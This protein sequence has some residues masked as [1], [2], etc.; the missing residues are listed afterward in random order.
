MR[1]AKTKIAKLGA[2]AVASVMTVGIAVPTLGAVAESMKGSDG[3]YSTSFTSHNA[4]LKSE[5]KL[6]LELAADGFALMK[7]NGALPLKSN[8]LKVTLL[9]AYSYSIQ[10]GGGGSGSASRPGNNDPV[11]SWIPQDNSKLHVALAG[12]GFKI[13]PTV[14]AKYSAGTAANNENHTYMELLDSGNGVVEFGGKNYNTTESNHLAGTEDSYANYGDAAIIN[15]MRTG[16]EFSDNSSH[17]VAQHADT[18]EHYQTLNDNERQLLAYAKYLKAQGKVKKLIIIINSPSNMEIADIEDDDAFDSILWIGTTGWDGSEVVGD[19]LKGDVNPSGHVVDFWEKDLYTNPTIYNWG[20]YGPAA[21]IKSGGETWDHTKIGASQVATYGWGGGASAPDMKYAADSSISPSAKVLHYAE[22]IFMGYRYYETVWAELEAANKG[23]GDT[24][25]D[26]NVIYPF[27]HGLSYT[28]FE[29]KITKVDGDLSKADGTITVTVEVKNTGDVA[30]KDVVQL[31]STPPYTAGGIDKAAVNLINFEKTGLIKAGGS[32][33]VKLEIAVKDLANFDWNDKNHN[34]YAGYELE[35]GKYTLSVRANSHDVLDS[36]DLTRSGGSLKWDED[37]DESTPN[38]I[39][40]QTS[41]PWEMYN[42]DVSHWLTSGT[43]YELHRDGILNSAKTG[44]SDLSKLI[45]LIGADNDNEFTEAAAAVVRYRGT[46]TA[47]DD[48]D[49]IV[50]AAKETDYD[51]NVW[52]KTAA[53]VEGWTQGTGV[54]DEDGL[55]DITAADMIGVDYDDAK[56]DTFLNQLTWAELKTVVGNTN[57]G[58]SYN[59]TAL[60]SVGK[61]QVTDQDGPGQLKANGKNGWFWVGETVIAS[62]WNKELAYAQGYHVGSES[63]W[64]EGG[65]WYGPAMNTHR[66]CLS[67]RN[68]EY[69]SQDGVQAGLIAGNVVGG[70]VD[71]GGRVYAKHIFLNDQ[72]ASRMNG[73]ATFCNEQAIREIYAKPFELC[74]R[75]GNCN[76]FMSAFP[77]V[78]LNSSGSYAMNI[79]MFTNEWG[80]KGITVTDMYSGAD[81]G[82]TADM[83][84]R[85]CIFPLGSTSAAAGTWDDTAKVVKVGDTT[86]YTQWYWV[87]ETTKRMLYT[88]VNSAAVN[89]GF[90]NAKVGVLSEVT[91]EAGQ[92]V[93]VKLVDPAYLKQY[94]GTDNYKISATNLP[95][96]LSLNPTT[97]VVSGKPLF[98]TESLINVGSGWRPDWQTVDYVDVTV[99]YC[100]KGNDGWI[101]GSS[102]VRFTFADNRSDEQFAT[103]IQDALFDS[104]EK[105]A[106]L[107]ARVAELEEALATGKV[108]TGIEA[109]ENGYVINFSDGTSITLTNGANGANGAQGPQGPAGAAG[110]QGPAGPAGADGKDAEGGC[111]GIIGAGA[112]IVAGL[113]ILGGAA[114]AMKRNKKD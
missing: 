43:D 25:Y 1:K 53:D 106:G 37:G 55:Y 8:E 74:V 84:V 12:D 69:Y 105:N 85:G 68:F 88:Y 92:N 56:W 4:V 5:S 100:G 49:N 27:G 19:I 41:G 111:G 60:P 58:G 110:A 44:P 78:G 2:F 29:Q 52:L 67:G 50:T 26:A 89:N 20:D 64:N 86:S 17:E 93:S 34:D 108:I 103:D 107:E 48:F 77:N 31:Y 9:G 3:K 36:T 98:K 63:V 87:R 81:S 54:A 79:Q 47:A 30:G 70:C 90:L 66:N 113:T 38:N 24:W 72:E 23:S 101:G 71:A 45:W 32:E 13:N 57:G 96:G 15:I 61:P 83:M 104:L 80:Y 33:T 11:Y 14:A 102:T 10:D 51:K 28:T 39:F 75:I 46:S 35:D 91:G 62:T 114:I 112:A 76:G 59:N 42:T 65:G 40:S 97:G 21:Y 99:T 7:N 18:T 22:G 16:S 82:W 94:F 6:N 73:L 109:I 95:L